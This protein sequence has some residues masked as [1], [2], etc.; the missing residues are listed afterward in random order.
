[1]LDEA[2]RLDIVAMRQNEFLVLRRALAL[3]GEFI[4][5]QGAVD[6]RHRHRLPLAL[7]ESE[8]V[9]AG[10]AQ[11]AAVAARKLVDHL[12]F[13]HADIAEGHGK[14]EVL[15]EKLH[16]DFAETDLADERMGA[17]VAALRRI[18]QTEQEALVAA[19]EALQAR[20]ARGRKA[21]RVAGD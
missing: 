4:G 1:M 18:G 17:A 19:R 21:R 3:L 16:L 14:A 13:G 20:V 12:A 8:T 5:A 15:D 7:S 10:E 2:G 6:E 11:R 9:A